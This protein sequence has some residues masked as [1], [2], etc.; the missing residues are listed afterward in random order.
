[1][2]LR[3]VIYELFRALL[4]DMDFYVYI[5]SIVGVLLTCLFPAK[6]IEEYEVALWCW[7]STPD[8]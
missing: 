3:A 1:M 7:Y 5:M 2:W 4:T 8:D 6:E